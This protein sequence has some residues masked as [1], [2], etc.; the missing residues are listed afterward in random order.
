MKQVKFRPSISKH[1]FD[2]KLN[3]IK[4]FLT[5]GHNVRITIMFRGREIIRQD[6]GVELLNKIEK[7]VQQLA[8]MQRLNGLK[9]RD[10]IAVLQVRKR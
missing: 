2:V 10:M 6:N 3:T 8:A 1:D 7:E 5:K 4:K 9:Q